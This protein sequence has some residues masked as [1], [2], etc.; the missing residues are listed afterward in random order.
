MNSDA[1]EE[2]WCANLKCQEKQKAHIL[3]VEEKLYWN[4]KLEADAVERK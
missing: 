1:E 4:C 3:E 2:A